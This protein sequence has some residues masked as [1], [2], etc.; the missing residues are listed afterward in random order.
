MQK[1]IG[2]FLILMLAVASLATA[3]NAANPY[4]AAYAVNN[5]I[6]SHYDI[7]Q[8][9]KLL[10]V[11]G[12][13]GTDVT[14]YATDQ[15]IGDQLKLGAGRDLGI[16]LL[17][18]AL[19][20]GIESAAQA[21]GMTG[22]ALWNK[23]K[24]RGVSRDAFEQY[25]TAQIVW[26]ELVQL[27]FRQ[28]SNPTSVDFDNAVNVAVSVTQK[29]ILLGEIALPFAERGE[30]ATLAFAERLSNDLNNGADFAQAVARFSRS[31]T[32]ANGGQ[33]GW[34]APDRLPPEV[35]A[36][37]RG[38]SSGMV[39]R[40]VRISTGVI[41][42]KVLATQVTG[43]PLQKQV[44]VRYSVLNLTGRPNAQSEAK[45]LQRKLDECNPATSHAANYGDGSG[46]FGPLAT[47][48]IPADISLALARLTAGN[49]EVLVIG[50]SVQLV[51]LCER[52]ATLGQDI[53]AQVNNNIFGNKIGKLAEGYLLELRR[54]AVIEKR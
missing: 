6:V 27:K 20:R 14:K 1:I 43:S 38:L 11:L 33:I 29:T 23:A 21:G 53:D 46:I 17:P 8:R 49:S 15:L 5:R 37:V 16:H 36:Q 7:T 18:D 24:A 30:A 35:A 44:A 28:F 34:V 45:Q 19:I 31:A 51:Q 22:D 39:S 13:Q 47:N 48:A 26:R 32:T 52:E 4:S 3:S 42:L 50:A 9:V 10:G 41:L 25:Y 12:Y 2:V 54:G 40:P